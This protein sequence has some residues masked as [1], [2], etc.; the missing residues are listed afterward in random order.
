MCVSVCVCLCK[1]CAR[2]AIGEKF[3]VREA[4]QED[5]MLFDAFKG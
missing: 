1:V 2:M 4:L 5:E 3:G